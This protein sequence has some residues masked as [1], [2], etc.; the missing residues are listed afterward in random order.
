MDVLRKQQYKKYSKLSKYQLFPVYYH[1]LDERYVQGGPA[2][3]SKDTG[4]VWHTVQ[5]N[6]TYDSISKE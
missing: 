2:N 5:H 1:S 4:Y 3:L 6:D